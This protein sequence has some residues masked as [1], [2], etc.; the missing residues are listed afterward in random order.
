MIRLVGFGLGIL[1][2]M[3]RVVIGLG[4]FGG[5]V[6]MWFWEI[7]WFFSSFCVVFSIVIVFGVFSV[8]G[9]LCNIGYMVR[10]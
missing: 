7:G 1:F 10:C 4:V 5:V 3:C 6:I 9:C 8:F 2:M